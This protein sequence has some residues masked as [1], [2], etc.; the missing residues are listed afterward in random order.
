MILPVRPD[1]IAQL[2]SAAADLARELRP[3]LAMLVRLRL[4]RR[5]PRSRVAYETVAL[6]LV[7]ELADVRGERAVL[8]R[9]Q[10][11]AAGRDRAHPPDAGVR[12]LLHGA[13]DGRR[14]HRIGNPQLPGTVTPSPAA[15]QPSPRPVSL[16]D[17]HPI[18]GRS[19][20]RRRSTR[21]NDI[22]PD[23]PVVAE[24]SGAVRCGIRL[25]PPRRHRSRA[26]SRGERARRQRAA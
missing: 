6:V 18:C 14:D 11:R 26:G 9:P 17:D 2:L 19:G 5:R 10:R 22:A 1:L 7:L 3:L 12:H 23:R 24:V 15:C 16:A 13:T 4:R 21:R 20:T 8:R 25:G